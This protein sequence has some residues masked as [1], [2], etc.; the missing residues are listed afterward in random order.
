MNKVSINKDM[1]LSEHF[2]LGEVTKTSVKTAGENIPSHVAIENLKNLCENWL[3]DLRYSYNTLY[4]SCHLDQAKRVERSLDYA[5]DDNGG[6]RDDKGGGGRDDK[7]EEPIIITSGYRSPEV[8]KA[9]GGSPTSNHLTGCAVD[10]RCVGIEQAIRYA[11]ILLDIA[12]GTKQDYDELF[13]ER[14][15]QGRYWIHFAVRPK[16]NRRKTAFIQT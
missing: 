11:C 9:V 6:A 5:R 1:H 10:I 16:D 13:I 3:E 7:G 15:K 14:S 8:N 2:Q 4:H 12:D